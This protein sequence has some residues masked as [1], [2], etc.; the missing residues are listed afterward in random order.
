MAFNSRQ[1]E[2]ADVTVILG[3]KDM[4]TIRGIKYKKTSDNEALFAKGRH[5]ISIQRGNESVEGEIGILQS[6]LI[7]LEE[8]APNKDLFQLSVDIEVSYSSNGVVRTD[9]VTGVRF[10][11]YEKSF[12]Q[13]DKFMEVPIPFL[14]LKVV[15]GV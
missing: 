1:Y 2:W 14:A 13:G 12:A 7:E 3:G 9:R 10:G 11:E 8:S 4:L 15:P 6:E 5:A